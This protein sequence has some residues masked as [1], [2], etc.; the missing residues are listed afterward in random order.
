MSRGR[1]G[2]KV[3][4]DVGLDCPCCGTRVPLAVVRYDGF[5]CPACESRLCVPKAYRRQLGVFSLALTI[6]G[7]YFSGARGLMLVIVSAIGLFPVIM[8]SSVVARKIVPPVL[9]IAADDKS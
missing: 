9:V 6:A 4:R 2:P 7:A 5:E 8:L 1:A 3:Q